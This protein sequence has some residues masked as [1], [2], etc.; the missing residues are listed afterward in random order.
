MI[1]KQFKH[2]SRYHICCCENKHTS[3][4]LITGSRNSCG[5]RSLLCV[6]VAGSCR[7]PGWTL[8]WLAQLAIYVAWPALL[9]LWDF[10]ALFAFGAWSVCRTDCPVHCRIRAASPASS[11]PAM[12]PAPSPG[13]VPP[14]ERNSPEQNHCDEGILVP[15]CSP[16]FDVESFYML[17]TGF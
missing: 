2:G 5:W 16:A 10:G 11:L 7:S 8:C 3:K 6:T 9:Q 15:S 14:A 13:C 1:Q 17:V 4:R 12:V